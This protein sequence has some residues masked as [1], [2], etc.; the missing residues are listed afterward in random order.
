[1]DSPVFRCLLCEQARPDPDVTCE[2]G[3]AADLHVVEG[4]G[5][6]CYTPERLNTLITTAAAQLVADR[7]R[8]LAAWHRARAVF[9]GQSEGGTRHA[10]RHRAEARLLD[11]LADRETATRAGEPA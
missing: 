3:A 9:W 6:V 10:L 1:M 5:L 8:Q 4:D 7:L 11:R 2:C